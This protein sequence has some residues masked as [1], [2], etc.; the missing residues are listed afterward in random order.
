M[1][2]YPLCPACKKILFPTK[3]DAETRLFYLRT[4]HPVL[5]GDVQRTYACTRGG[6]GWHM[7]SKP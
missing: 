2:H 5:H 7:T 6:S 1:K 4:I 3:E